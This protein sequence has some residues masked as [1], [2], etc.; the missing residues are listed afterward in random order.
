MFPPSR[1]SRSGPNPTPPPLSWP[2]ELLEPP[3]Y[4][5]PAPLRSQLWSRR[6]KPAARRPLRSC[7][8]RASRPAQYVDS[9][10][11]PSSPAAAAARQPAP[12][13]V[14]RSLCLPTTIR[15]V[16]P[17]WPREARAASP[18]QA[19]SRRAF[20]THQLREDPLMR[21]SRRVDSESLAARSYFPS[22]RAAQPSTAALRRTEAQG[23]Q[24]TQHSPLAPSL[25]TAPRPAAPWQSD[26]QAPQ[27]STYARQFRQTPA[28]PPAP[29]LPAST[30][31]VPPT[32]PT[33]WQ[34][35]SPP[36]LH[37]TCRTPDLRATSPQVV[38][39]KPSSAKNA[40]RSAR[41]P[42]GRAPDR[43]KPQ[44]SPAPDSLLPNPCAC[45]PL[46]PAPDFGAAVPPLPSLLPAP[47][48]F[49]LI[50]SLKLRTRETPV[51][52]APL[53]HYEPL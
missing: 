51:L 30:S 19:T 44:E 34:Y 36:P 1:S 15:P 29:Q 6:R 18:A 47:P 39:G 49:L 40:V 48:F 5:P 31:A 27:A 8:P 45:P 16:A 38:P 21:P 20:P 33:R 11:A 3:P 42:A 14:S 43:N 7:F 17:P 37:R 46:R 13:K 28:A 52:A 4:P 22:W 23:L 25:A 24:A 41:F 32:S 53:R 10:A 26:S 50:R 35:F 12:P 2:A 9:P